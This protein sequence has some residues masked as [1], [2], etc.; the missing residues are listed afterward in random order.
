[1]ENRSGSYFHQ[2]RYGQSNHH[3]HVIPNSYVH[4]H[5]HTHH[6]SNFQP[7][8]QQF[9]PP[10]SQLPPPHLPPHPL[11]LPP[12][13]Q[14]QQ[15]PFN[16]PR[17][18]FNSTRSHPDAL[19]FPQSP[20]PSRLPSDFIGG[21]FQSRALQP[22]SYHQH[23]L[24]PDSY[25]RQ[26]DHHH[27]HHQPMSPI[28]PRII[29]EHKQQQRGDLSF[30]SNS[31]DFRI[32]ASNN[33]IN[34]TE[35]GIENQRWVRRGR[36]IIRG[37]HDSVI[38]DS[39]GN[40]KREHYRSSREFNVES[41]QGSSREGSH[42]FS[43][44]TPRKQ[45]P[46]KS[47][48]LRIQKPTIQ[49]FRIRDDDRGHHYS[50]YFD[51]TNYSSSFR[52]IKDK[53]QNLSH[54]DRET[55]DQVREG[56]TMELDVSFKSNSLVAKAIVTPSADVSNSNLPPR[57]GKLRNK[58]KNSSSSSP[59]KA[60]GATIK[61]DNV[62]SVAKN[63]SSS[64]KDLKQSKEEV[65]VSVSSG[66]KV[67]IGKNKGESPTKGT[68][69]NKGGAN[70]VSGKAS[71]LKVLKKKL[72]KRPVKKAINPNL[73][74]SSSKL[75]K[76]S[77][78]PIIKDSFV[79]AQPAY[80]QPD[81]EAAIT[82]VNVVDSQP[83][84]NETN[85]MPEKCRVE[86]CAEA[87][88]SENGASAGFGRLCLPNIK[89]KR[90]HSTSPL[91]SSSL[92][93]TKINENMVND[94]STNYSHAILNT[95]KD[96]TKLLN[97][98]TGSDI[99]AVED[100]AKQL[101]QSGDS[102]LL[103]NNA[104]N[105][106]PK[107]LLSAE[108]NADCGC[109]NSVKTKIHEG[110]AGSS[111]MILG[112]ES[113]NGLINLTERTTVFDNGITD[114]GCKQPCTN[115]VSPSIEDDIVDQFVNGSSQIWQG[116]SGEMTNGIVARSASPSIEGV[117]TTF[118][119]NNGNHVSR[120]IS[121]SS[122]GASISKQPSP[123]RVGISF[124]NVPVRG[125]LS[126]MVSMGG[127]EEDDTLNIDKSDIK[128]KSSEL[129]FSKSEVNDVYAEP[130][131]M[132]TSA[133]VD[134]TLRLS[135]K[136]PT[137]TEFIVSG[138]E[139]RDVDQRPHTD[140]ANVLTQRSSMDVSEANISVSSTTSVCPNAGLIQN[141][142]KR[143]ITGS[144]L[145]MY[146][147]MTSDVVEGPIITGISVSTAELPCN[148]GCSSDLPSVQK[149]TTASLNCSRVR[150][151]STAAPFRDVF[152]KDGL[153]CISSCSTAEELSVPKVKSVC[154]TG[155]EGEKIAGTTPVMAGISHQNN[156]IHAESGEGEKMDVDAVE[157]QLIVD[158]GTSQCQCPSEVQ[159]LNSDERMPVV[160]VEDENCLDAKNGLPSASNN[161]FSLRDCNGTSTT[162]T[163]GEAMVLV[164]DTLPNMD[165][166]ET[167]PDAPSILQSSLSIKQAGGND[168]ILLGMS[169][170]QGGSGI[171]AV[172]SGSL[173]TEDHAVENA[174]SFGGKATL[175]S[176]DTKS[177][178][179]TLNAMSK[180][181]SGRKSHHNIAA[182]PGRSSFVFLAS[183]STAP[184]NHISKPRTW[185]R[186]DSSFAPALPGNKVFSSTVPT[187]CQLPKKVTKFHNTSYIRKGNSL[188]RKP[189]LVAAQPLGS[190]GLSSSAYWLNSSGKYE[191]KK[192]TDTRTGVADP[193]NFVKSGVGAS[194]ER[195]R[196][197]PLPSSTKISNH[198]TN[199][200]GD[201]LS[202]PLVERL[203]ICAA[204]AASDPVTSTESNDV[205]KSSED[206]VKVS[207][208][209]MFQTGQIN[210]LDC[211]TEQNDGN[212]VSSN[213]KSIKY[214]K[215]KSNQL[216]ATSNPCSL[217]MKNSHSTAAL[218]SDGYYKRRKNQL[219]RTSVENHEKPTAS[220]PDES[221]N[222]EG[223]ALHNITSGRSLTKRR[224]RKVVAKTRKPSKFSSVWTLHSAQSLKDD[225]HSLHSQKVLPQ[226]LPWKR[227]TSWRSFIPSSA[228]ISI[229][230]SSSLIRKL[231][232]LRKRD[233]VYTRS[234]HGYSLRKSK[235]LSVGGSSLKWSKSIERQSKKANEE[236]TLAVAEAERKKR[237][238][239]GASHVDTGTKNRNSS[240]RKAVHSL[241][242]HPGE[243]IFRIGSVRYKMD[244]SRRTL[245][246]ISDDESSHLAALQ[247]EKDAKR[248]YVPRRLVIG[249][250]E[251]VRIGNGNQLVRD[252]KKR[253]RILAS[254]KVRWSLH[255]ARSRLARKRKY[256]QF[257]T[258]FGKCNKDD[259][260]CPYIH[261]SSKIAVCTKFL[262]G[263]CFNP[264]CKLTHK[265]IPERMPDCS[266]FLQGLCSNE[267][268]PYRH[269]HVNPNASTCEGFLR[270]YCNDGNECQKK[271]SYVCPTYEATGSCPE[272]SKCKLHHPKI[273]IKGRK[274]KQ[275][276]EKKNSRGRYFGSMH[277]NISEPGTAVSEK[278]SVQENDNFC[279]EGSISD[280]ISLDVSD[281][282]EE[283][284]NPADKQTS[285][286]DS[287]ALDLEL[288]DLDE[289]IKPIRIMNT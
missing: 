174:N 232:L 29:E 159:S 154:P 115:E 36:E 225:S 55:G 54:L 172:T 254:E 52:G 71:S 119:S 147:P 266:Y 235:V 99:G 123:D 276:R 141:Q 249:K 89:R 219:I 269:V 216:I 6:Q 49:K 77:D 283:N 53:D 258:R 202:S 221:V 230:G 194:F 102:L 271:H 125:S 160:N 113:D 75:T 197:P 103:E 23:P 65:K 177:S 26:L 228:A 19:N 262:N 257:F 46:K 206:T 189:T 8:P 146:C 270:G 97:E 101:C 126:R 251:Y 127:R 33:Q 148:S 256:C 252:P 88:V 188:V 137:P 70:V 104:A 289:L 203:H 79:H 236:A 244:S 173:I 272:G 30:G 211:E 114:G 153:R 117:G 285:L 17:F 128:V 192:N 85:V 150:Y 253:T 96:Y 175:P 268:C 48:L 261:D 13:Q 110:P 60:N 68:V 240:S 149:E 233:T 1:M 250:D 67:S 69:S 239:F 72:V 171:S 157:E 259:G 151:D 247:T 108:G 186:T 234:K 62:V 180:E 158:S 56:S 83:C 92:E 286:C 121:L 204:E 208:K 281:E 196:T 167:L 210:N 11:P 118:D 278:H 31:R 165:Y 129:D 109:S 16:N 187:K 142:K 248:Y 32:A 241:K 9:R 185:H 205:L 7:A 44:T 201:C 265:V 223:Q 74:S 195:P 273:R 86:G 242:L 63:T 198:P 143:K 59:S 100:A 161:L 226:L 138:D 47:A 58:D 134:T 20:P 231:L 207:E 260:K 229:N 10:Q 287:D 132:V 106:S 81:K 64:D 181:I 35:E 275:L 41:G 237:E 3:H 145:E 130:V 245:Q 277:V 4:H 267:N 164:P 5:N 18:P 136:D 2:T 263:L 133:W 61:L 209:H 90:S 168:E 200:M 37:V 57:N 112:Y 116:T 191:V 39:D 40:R 21:D 182:Y 82:S 243:R 94:D 12:Y 227:A 215:R 111:D 220:M 87:M 217:S 27:H 170:T 156:S 45:L 93:E 34:H 25:R 131:N 15:H 176:Q 218:P 28:N 178:T 76:K 184:S 255:T 42:E 91:G 284:S 66:T 224:S 73:Y 214:V 212:A 51:H 190:H 193:P 155:F 183:T 38:S 280:Y 80:F 107:Y 179:Q 152:E 43:R 22:G 105:G 282:A 162:D 163:S 274:S 169:A 14:Q 95:D 78:G 120:E 124:E 264:V 279:F 140:G 238:R 166:Q 84:T 24:D 213:A 50:A 222:T 139:H 144:Q 199:S 288:V 246:R 98:T 122:N 135:F